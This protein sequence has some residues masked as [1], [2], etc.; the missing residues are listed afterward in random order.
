VAPDPR[1]AITGIFGPWETLPQTY[2]LATDGTVIYRAEGFSAGEGEIIA[3]KTER[4]YL[5]KGRPFSSADAAGVSAAPP[6]VGEEAPSIR[7][8]QQQD[9]RYQSSIVAGD[10]AFMAWDFDRALAAYAAA[11]EAQPRDLHALVRSAQIHERR[12][13]V[14]AALEF[15]QRVLAV[16]PGHAEA[17]GRV[18]DLQSR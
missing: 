5:L 10:A 6:P 13:E 11:L 3:G 2:L 1:G 17:A 16:S 18:R 8:R 9:E 12:G 4:A 15:W 14:P 7:R